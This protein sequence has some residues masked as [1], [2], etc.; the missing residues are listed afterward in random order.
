LGCE[1]VADNVE[2]LGGKVVRWCY[3]RRS[4]LGGGTSLIVGYTD[5]WH[6]T[7][8]DAYGF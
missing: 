7:V 2:R 5:D 1:R 3:A 6:V 4:G 8:T